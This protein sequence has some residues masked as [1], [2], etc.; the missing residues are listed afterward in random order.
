ML[1]RILIKYLIGY[2]RIV[3]EGYYI[4]RFINICTTSNILI[5]NLQREKNIRLYLNIGINDFKKISSICKKTK[6]RVK[7]KSKHGIPFLLNKYRKRKIFVILL[8]AISMSIYFSSNY[9]WNIEIKNDSGKQF[10]NL[11][12]DLNT[13]GLS[14][15]KLKSKIDTK[16][17]INK[18]RLKRDDVA[19]IGI[20]LKGT[21]AIVKVIEADKAPEI[22]DENEYCNIIAN[23][24]GLI[25]KISAQNGTAQVKEGD[26]VQQGAI[27]IQGIMEGKY[28]EP[29][30]VHASGEIQAKVWYTKSKKIYFNQ[31]EKIQTGNEEKNLGIKINN[32]KIFFPKRVSK[33]ELYDTIETEKKLKLFSD[34]YLPISVISTTYKE[35]EKK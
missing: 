16:D 6:C 35:I 25:T 14:V 28:T 9:I 15:G 34:F 30:Y 17:V 19:W 27:L 23:K 20:E 10:E 22:I 24:S 32:F 7:I 29:R 31:E 11:V 1:I 13:S 18:I 8:I 26:V 5:W 21:N 2:V 3:V 12:E 4:E 33:F